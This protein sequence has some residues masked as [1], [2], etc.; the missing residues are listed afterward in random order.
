MTTMRRRFYDLARE[1]LDGDER[2]AVVTAQI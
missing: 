2:V 1:A